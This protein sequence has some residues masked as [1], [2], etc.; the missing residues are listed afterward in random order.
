[1]NKNPTPSRRRESFVERTSE[2]RE[3]ERERKEMA[4]DSDETFLL[5]VPDS[6]PSRWGTVE[7]KCRR[8][9]DNY[10]FVKKN[11]YY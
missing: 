4:V 5:A 1:M 6:D 11:Y 2:E 9:V 7:W 8:L 3:R 10:A